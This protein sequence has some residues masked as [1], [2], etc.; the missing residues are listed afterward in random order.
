MHWRRLGVAVL[1]TGAVATSTVAQA[2]DISSVTSDPTPVDTM[3]LETPAPA[4]YINPLQE[5][6]FGVFAHNWIHDEGAPVDV[7]VE[8]LSS[9]LPLWNTTNP[10]ISWFFNPRLSAG[11]MINTE[12]KTS[13]GFLGFAWRIPIYQKFFF[14]GE[15]GGAVNDSPMHPE[16]GRVDMGCRFTFR[17]SA[18]LGYQFTDKIDIITSIEHVSHATFCT[19]INPGL[20]QLGVRIGYKF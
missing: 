10:W 15:F 20:T 12:G 14:E 11:G 4:P 16:E 7:S 1:L 9:T 17:E 19:H 5:V 8:V 2:A 3:G 6:R 13:Y 18:G